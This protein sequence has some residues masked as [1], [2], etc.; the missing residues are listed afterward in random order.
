M[1]TLS[2]HAATI[3]AAIQAARS[4]GFRVALEDG[5]SYE[6]ASVDLERWVDT[7]GGPR[8]DGWETIIEKFD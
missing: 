1:A 5:D 4:D 3:E 7:D 2:E 6:N 8:L